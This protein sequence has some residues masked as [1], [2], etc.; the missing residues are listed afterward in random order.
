MCKL[1]SNQFCFLY[2]DMTELLRE[3]ELLL[4]DLE[5]QKEME[6][7][8]SSKKICHHNYNYYDY[9]FFASL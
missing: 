9:V 2:K 1:I 7:Y 4:K 3:E 5:K 8:V 6:K